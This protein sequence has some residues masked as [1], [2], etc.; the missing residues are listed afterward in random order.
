M[1]GKMGTDAIR[2]HYR[3][4]NATIAR[5]RKESGIIAKRNG[6]KQAM[7][8]PADFKE[9]GVGIMN[10]PLAEHYGVSLTTIGQWRRETNTPSTCSNK[11]VPRKIRRELPEDF[12]HF[13]RLLGQGAL[14]VHYGT[15]SDTIKRW[16]TES[17]VTYSRPPKPVRE[18]RPKRLKSQPFK[19]QP[20]KRSIVSVMGRAH[21]TGFT[22]PPDT[23]IE[24][25][26]AQVLRALAPTYRCDKLGRQ[27]RDGDFWRYGNALLTPDE[28]LVRATAKGWSI[29]A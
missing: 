2:I 24:G 29:A 8:I 1:C 16:R 17:G 3:A 23:S 26:A 19:R 21:K 25:S 10:R 27:D 18:P 20:A 9:R 14:K 5:W 22:I 15:G 12:A 28:L 7:G 11:G 13:G 4:G 6:G